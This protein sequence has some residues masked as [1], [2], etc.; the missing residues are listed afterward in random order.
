MKAQSVE[1]QRLSTAIKERDAEI[2]D[3]RSRLTYLRENHRELLRE[4]V[5][6]G[7]N[8]PPAA[9]DFVSSIL[10]PKGK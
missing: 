9:A 7:M 3:L 2:G 4:R 1:I 6:A 10:S 5:E 8:Q